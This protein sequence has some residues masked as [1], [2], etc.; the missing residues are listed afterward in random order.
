MLGRQRQEDHCSPLASQS[1]KSVKNLVSKTGVESK[2]EDILNRPL[3]STL[4]GKQGLGFPLSLHLS[5][6]IIGVLCPVFYV[7]ASDLSSGPHA[8]ITTLY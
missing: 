8:H 6:E 7:G 3:A 4:A 5:T 1:N 2:Q